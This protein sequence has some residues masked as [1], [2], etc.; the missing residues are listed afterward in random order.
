MKLGISY[1]VFDAVEL[2]EGSIKC[3]RDYV[4]FISV[5]WQDISNFGNPPSV[6]T[7][8]ILN[9]LKSKGL[10]DEIYKY[11][12]QI[13]VGGHTNELNKRN[14]GLYLSEG[15]NC[16]HHMSMDTDEYYLTEEFKRMKEDVDTQNYDSSACQMLSYYKSTEYI[17]DPPE[18]YYVPL[19]Y[20]IRKHTIFS[21]G[22]P[23]PVLVDPTRSMVAGR[24]VTYTRDMIQMHHLTGV[25][26]NYR[27]KLVNSSASINF[28][29]Q[30]DNLVTYF[31]QWQYPKKALMPGLPPKYY[32]V[33]K[34]QNLFK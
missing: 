7:E 26:D 6:N 21:F 14:I 22:V 34:V 25:R 10:I 11:K 4:D 18:D 23:F 31:N 2:L 13:N 1:N 16:T 29:D 12:P 3:I 28:K 9:D 27:E 24:C 19:I 32:N 8:L 5:V 15:A 17:L 33:K 20:K 30:I